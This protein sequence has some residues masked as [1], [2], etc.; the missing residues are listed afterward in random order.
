MLEELP[1][2]KKLSRT[3]GYGLSE[4]TI[5]VHAINW[6][7]TFNLL[8]ALECRSYPFSNLCIYVP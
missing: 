8:R 4:R 6:T 7:R 2:R 1:F 3:M 5:T